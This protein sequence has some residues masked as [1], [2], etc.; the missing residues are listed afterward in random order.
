VHNFSSRGDVGAS[1]AVTLE[2]E[3]VVDLWGGY[4]DAERTRPWQENTIV[5]VFSVTKTMTFMC[6]LI[7]ADRGLLEFEAPVARY[8]PEFVVNGKKGMKIRHLLSHSAGLPGFSRRFTIA[9]MGD[10]EF[11]CENLAAQAPWWEPGMCSGYHLVTQGYLLGEVIRRITGKS[12]GAFFR[13]EIAARVGADFHIGVAPGD[14]PRIADVI[15]APASSPTFSMDPRSVAARALRTLD[16]SAEATRDPVWRQAE[17]PAAN[18][19]GNARS[20]VR[21]QTA[22]A[23]EGRAFGVELLS[24]S[25]CRRAHEV[26]HRGVDVVLNLELA[27]TS[28]Y[29]LS[30]PVMPVS[31]NPATL[32]WC[33]AGGSTIVVDTS[34]RLC[35]SYVMNR[36]SPYIMG[37]SRG[38]DLGK[39]VYA[40]LGG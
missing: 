40:S 22:M 31:P 18:G 14:F 32:W 25:G 9:E 6:V 27:Y 38:L 24:E 33:G 11:V 34:R 23:N 1:F 21:A 30:S 35:M 10:W 15:A 3:Y 37:D 26:L 36:M 5:N 39:A 13:D 8:W 29:A 28:G 4:Q 20:V 12:P 7:L 16:I 2:G 17:I 19:H